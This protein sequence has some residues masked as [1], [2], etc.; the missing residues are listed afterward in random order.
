MSVLFLRV[1]VDIHLKHFSLSVIMQGEQEYSEWIF[2]GWTGH[3]LV[4]GECVCVC[5]P[6]C[7][8]MQK[9]FI[10]VFADKKC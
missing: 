7:S 6:I 2:L 5:A 9:V 4:A 10:H 3:G 8:V 1:H